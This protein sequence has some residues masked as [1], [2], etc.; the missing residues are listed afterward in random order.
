[1]AGR[2][3]SILAALLSIV[4]VGCTEP[5]SRGFSLPPGDASRG[6]EVF[7]QYGCSACHVIEGYG[8][9]RDGL[10]AEA[11]LVL[12]GQVDR[13]KTYGELVTSVINPSHRLSTNYP[14]A[15]VMKSDGQSR[16]PTVNEAMTIAEL[17]DLIAFLE[18]QYEIVPY[19]P[20]M[21]PRYY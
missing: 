12:G 18:D 7:A 20:T 14:F 3:V 6:L 16:M 5:Q 15:T 19:N 13:V 4:S 10:E 2:H 8:Y 11:D 9:L 1:M 21:Y 17:V